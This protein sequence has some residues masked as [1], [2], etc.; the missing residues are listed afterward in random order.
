MVVDYVDGA[1][2]GERSLR[3]SV[4]AFDR[5][6]FRPRVLR[7]VGTV[8]TSTDA[9]GRSIALPLVLG[10]T[11]F[12]RMMHREGESAVARAA[13]AAGIPYTL[14]TM[15]RMRRPAPETSRQGFLR[16]AGD[17]VLPVRRPDEPD[18]LRAPDP[19]LCCPDRV[20]A[21]AARAVV[22]RPRR[23]V[24]EHGTRPSAPSGADL[25]GRRAAP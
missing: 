4:E 23:R 5:V 1:A 16:A 17:R 6:T 3:A 20:L 21:I 7:D 8:S 25:Q 18:V 22:M 14:S 24:R 2:E 13:A 12:T 15:V 10:P 9:L 19:P 11:G